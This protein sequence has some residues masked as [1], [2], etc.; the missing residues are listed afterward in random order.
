[1][2]RTAT[3]DSVY[4]ESSTSHFN[5]MISVCQ[6]DISSISYRRASVNNDVAAVRT[7]AFCYYYTIRTVITNNYI[8]STICRASYSTHFLTRTIY[9]IRNSIRNRRTNKLTRNLSTD[10]QNHFETTTT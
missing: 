9:A 10:I 6:I 2:Q 8:P 3:V 7:S 4:R 5:C 1:R